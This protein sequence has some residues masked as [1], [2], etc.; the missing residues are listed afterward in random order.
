[1]VNNMEKRVAITTSSFGEHQIEPINLLRN[2]GLEIILNTYGRQLKQHEILELCQGCQGIIA[3]TEKYDGTVFSQLKELRVI[4]RCGTGLDNIDL[5]AAKACGIKIL[6]TPLAPV[7]AV[8]ELTVGMI[9]NLL[10]KVNLMSMELGQGTWKKRMGNLLYGK[11][12]GIIGFGNIGK[13]V[14]ELLMPFE[15]DIGYFDLK[16]D[17]THNRYKRMGFTDLL[18]WADIVTLHCS[19]TGGGPI[20]GENEFALL[21]KGSWLINT[22]RGDLVDEGALFSALT[23]GRINGA[24]ID[25]FGSEPYDGPLTKLSNV[26][27]TPHIGSYAMESRI[28]MELEAVNN[29]IE[30]LENL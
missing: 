14:A 29:L 19:S 21:K 4:S 23:E 11:K 8:A 20:I 28:A 6:N 1:M 17:T 27:L 10:R 12:V 13:K 16:S 25:V 7:Q 26:I 2:K 22:A 3:G 30:G 15:T 9:I 24:A 5:I 18:K